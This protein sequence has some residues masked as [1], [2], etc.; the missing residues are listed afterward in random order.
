[1]REVGPVSWEIK[2]AGALLCEERG[3]MMAAA[4]AVAVVVVVVGGGSYLFRS[5]RIV[6][7]ITGNGFKAGPLPL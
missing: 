1:M 3:V 4:A 2:A 6:W 5:G 7:T